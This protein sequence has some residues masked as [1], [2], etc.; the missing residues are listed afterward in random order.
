MTL[1]PATSATTPAPVRVGDLAVP[2][3]ETPGRFARRLWL[4]LWQ[5]AP[6]RRWIAFV[7]VP[8]LLAFAALYVVNGAVNGWRITYEVTLAI[9]SPFDR[10]DVSHV[11]WALPLSVAGWLLAP[12]FIGAIVGYMVNRG[13]DQQRTATA[14]EISAALRHEVARLRSPADEA[15]DDA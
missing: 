9:T 2:P 12:S 10:P 1:P 8:F 7:G 4:S 3:R 5:L 11:W 15:A 6:F 13:I 14:A